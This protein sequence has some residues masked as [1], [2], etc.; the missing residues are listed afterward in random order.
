MQ[1]SS[2]F[3]YIAIDTI[4]ESANNPRITFDPARLEELA[5]RIRQHGLIQPITVRPNAGDDENDKRCAEDVLLDTI[6][7]PAD[8]DEID[9]LAEAEAALV[10]LKPGKPASAKKTKAPIEAGPTPTPKKKGAA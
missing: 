6:G 8:E 2:A 9:F 3:Q 5:A 1:D 7:G 10:L 4:H